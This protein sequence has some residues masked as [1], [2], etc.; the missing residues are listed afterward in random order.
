[1]ADQT[2]LVPW[3]LWIAEHAPP[4]F[5]V[6]L[7]SLLAATAA[8]W[9]LVRRYTLSTGLPIAFVVGAALAGVGSFAALATQL[10]AGQVP[11]WS[12]QAFTD[13]LRASAPQLALQ[14]FAVVTHLGDTLTLTLLC[15]VMAL[16]LVARGQRGLALGWVVAVAGNGMLNLSLKQIFGRVRPL[17][18]DGV[19]VEHGFSFP[20]GHSS[21]AVVACGMLA[22]LAL[23]LLP[24][25]WHLPMLMAMVTIAVTVGASRMFLGAHFASDV[26]AGFASGSAWLAL[27]V[28]SIEFL[29]RR[30]PSVR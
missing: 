2:L 9:W 4:I 26:A 5:L 7:A 24:A 18:S 3:I 14:L 20:S 6:S 17:N 11:G 13:A 29:Q 23:R 1:M 22:Y 28:T 8:G 27:C 21:G 12:D 16:A 10:A 30:R 15:I 25:R 19:V